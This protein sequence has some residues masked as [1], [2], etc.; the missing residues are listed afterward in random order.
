MAEETVIRT[1]KMEDGRIV[2]FTGK[3][4]LIKTSNVEDLTVRLDWENGQTRTFEIPEKLVFK[5][6]CHGME[7]KLGDEI[8]GAKNTDGSPVETDDL[9]LAV[10]E[11]IE[12]LMTEGLEGWT[13]KREASGIAGTSVLLRAIVEVTKKPIESIR[14]Y[15]K[16][17][18]Q[19]DKM[20]LRASPRFKA[21]VER[22]EAEKAAKGPKVDTKALEAELDEIP[23]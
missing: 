18:T 2:E 20:Q 13:T 1:V 14:A 9:V 22:L 11:L 15:L 6:A 5:S 7:Q 10:D 21:V 12:R 8:A 3:K 23:A 19:A 4:R 17:K 16:K